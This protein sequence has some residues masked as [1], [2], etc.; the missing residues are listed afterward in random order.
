MRINQK[1]SL[2]TDIEQSL[3]TIFENSEY[4]FYFDNENLFTDEVFKNNTLLPLFLFDKQKLIYRFCD[5]NFGENH[6][7]QVILQE[8]NDAF[9]NFMVQIEHNLNNTSQ[10]VLLVK[11]ITSLI[12]ADPCF[13]EFTIQLHDK[14]KH[15]SEVMKKTFVQ[16]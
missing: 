14:Y 4:E 7:A 5:E 10:Y 3:T 13:N 1:Y 15:L 2:I 6:Y 9:L 12:L 11:F 16:H 8:N